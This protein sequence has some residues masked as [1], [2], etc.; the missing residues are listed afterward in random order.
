MLKPDS[1]QSWGNRSKVRLLLTRRSIP[2]Q[3]REVAAAAAGP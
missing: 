1:Y 3:A 2:F